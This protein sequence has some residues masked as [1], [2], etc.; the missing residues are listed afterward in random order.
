MK[1]AWMI[2]AG[3]L[4]LISTGA[5]ASDTDV[6]PIAWT[7][8]G[9]VLGLYANGEQEFLG[10]PYATPPVGDR[11]WRAP[12]RAAP[13]IAPLDASHFANHCPQVA[14][15]FRVAST[16]ENCQVQ[17]SLSQYVPTWAY[18]FS[19]QN[20]PQRYLAPA[21]FPYGAYHSAELQYLFDLPVTVP[22]PALTSAQEELSAAMVHY[23][24]R[25]SLQGDPNSFATP[26]CLPQT[27]WTDRTESLVTPAPQP[28]TAAEFGAYH[29]CAFWA[30]L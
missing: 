7:D 23:W 27:S 8:W 17:R 25:F 3:A 10:I 1:R 18:E 6:R 29:D 16:T 5:Q 13:W 21:S 19:D 12:Q 11:R 24:T 28:Y 15:P 2:V 26:F 22:V 14:T 4:A 30:S 20:A 9:P